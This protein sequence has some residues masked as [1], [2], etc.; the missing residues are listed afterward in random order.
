MGPSLTEEAVSFCDHRNHFLVYI[1]VIT[2]INP[3]FEVMEG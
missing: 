3:V 1:E 2:N